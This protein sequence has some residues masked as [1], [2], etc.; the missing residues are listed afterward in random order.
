MSGVAGCLACLLASAIDDVT[1]TGFACEKGVCGPCRPVTKAAHCSSNSNFPPH[2]RIY[3]HLRRRLRWRRRIFFLYFSEKWRYILLR[4][5]P[6][7][8]P[9]T[10]SSTCSGGG[11]AWTGGNT[12]QNNSFSF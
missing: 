7:F 10:V 3:R 6:T 1:E 12:S 11:P 9:K 4:R 2:P 8:C 5:F